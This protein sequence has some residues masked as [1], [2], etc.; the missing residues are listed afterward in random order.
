[1]TSTTPYSQLQE[2]PP[3]PVPQIR[4]AA[5][6]AGFFGSILAHEAARHPDI[7]VELVADRDL[8]SA[9]SLAA[10]LDAQA[11]DDLAQVTSSD[12][13][14][15]FVA[16]PNHLHAAHVL[17]AL[18]AGKHV[19]VEKPLTIT[20]DDAMALTT[21]A[22]RTGR[23]LMVGHVLRTLPGVLRMHRMATS[24]E[25]GELLEATGTRTRVVHVPDGAGDWWKLDPSRS[26][27]ELLHELHELDLVCWFLG[28]RPERV[29]SLSGAPVRVAEHQLDTVTRTTMLFPNRAV[30]FH[31][32]STSAHASAW[33]FRV[34]GTEAA[35]EVD[36]KTA[37]VRHVVDGHEVDA[38][39]VFDDPTANES[40]R[41]SARS[42]QAYHRHNDGASVPPSWMTR[43]V[44]HEMDQV[45]HTLT[46]GDG[47]LT[48]FPDSA[49][50]AALDA[51]AAGRVA[52][53]DAAR[54][55][56]HA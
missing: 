21:A 54:S 3:M 33:S 28:G 8:S 4:A 19:F 13:D 42:K 23:L 40:L 34:T 49:V 37:T 29:V 26:G 2:D 11:V 22:A 17:A 45:V 30:G 53:G 5:L 14:L 48:Q 6:G 55:T 15:V 1:M 47:V 31:D 16:T 32:L 39:G 24:G 38:W 18:E 41:E 25:L 27:G 56:V 36:F 52:L 43:A 44:R 35:L 12:V 50:L 51:F 20:A 46:T 10:R 9:T 7:Q